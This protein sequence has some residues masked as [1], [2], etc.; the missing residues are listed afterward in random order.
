[1]NDANKSTDSHSDGDCLSDNASE[2]SIGTVGTSERKQHVSGVL[3]KVD[4]SDA[5]DVVA[6]ARLYY[7]L[8]GR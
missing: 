8:E 3:P 6:K 4:I 7:A 5:L 2:Y 1:V